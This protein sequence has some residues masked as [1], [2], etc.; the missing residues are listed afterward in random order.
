MTL[1][2][3]SVLISAFDKYG[4][5]AIAKAFENQIMNIEN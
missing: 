2:M 1:R 5:I 3:Y 4:F